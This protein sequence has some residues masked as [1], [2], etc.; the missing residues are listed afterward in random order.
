MWSISWMHD[1]AKNYISNPSV[2]YDV[3]KIIFAG[4]KTFCWI[5]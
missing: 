3:H 2:D 5:Y 4:K 1:G